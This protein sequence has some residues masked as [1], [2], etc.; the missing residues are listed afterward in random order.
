M[1]AKIGDALRVQDVDGH[2]PDRRVH[3]NS[4]SRLSPFSAREAKPGLVRRV[5]VDLGARYLLLDRHDEGVDR[6]DTSSGLGGTAIKNH[7]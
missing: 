3:V 4:R 6:L 5:D 1:P 2:L 7:F